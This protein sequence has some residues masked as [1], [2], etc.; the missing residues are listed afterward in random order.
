MLESIASQRTP[1]PP[2]P[3]LVQAALPPPPPPLT[4]PPPATEALQVDR[5]ALM[6]A[7]QAA[8]A[9]VESETSAECEALLWERR[10]QLER[11]MQ[12]RHF[13]NKETLS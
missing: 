4:P 1:P 11:E 8:R 6:M 2:S 5:L 10:L 7:Q 12:V 13:G 3:P 9:A